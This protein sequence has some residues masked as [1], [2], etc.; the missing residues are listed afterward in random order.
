MRRPALLFLLLGLALGA[1]SSAREP[2]QLYPRN[3]G[4]ILTLRV[5]QI[6]EVVLDGDPGTDIH[7][8]KNP[9]EEALLEQVGET[10]YQTDYRAQ[11]L[12]R[13]LMTRFRARAPGRM[14]L[15]LAYRAPG[16]DLRGEAFEVWLVIKE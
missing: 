15:R 9:G 5:G 4:E 12:E 2:L 8:L 14:R 7:W 11:D 1:C 10:T 6:V 13:R 16:G 3:S